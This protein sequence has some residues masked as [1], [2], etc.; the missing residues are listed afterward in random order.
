MSGFQILIWLCRTLSMVGMLVPAAAAT[1]RYVAT[2]GDDEDAGT[3]AQP[4]KHISH[5]V[6]HANAGDRIFVL[7]GTYDGAHGETFPINVYKTNQQVLSYDPDQADWARIGG[8]VADDDVVA[9]LTID[10]RASGSIAAGNR[11]GIVIKNLYF[12][13]EDVADKD[14]PHAF[15]AV[16]DGTNVVASTCSFT[17]NA[18]ERSEMNAS[19]SNGRAN[20]MLDATNGDINMLVSLNEVIAT[21]RGGIEAHAAANSATF[22]PLRRNTISVRDGETALFAIRFE[23]EQDGGTGP[24]DFTANII[25]SLWEPEQA[26]G[27]LNGIEVLIPEGGGFGH[28]NIIACEISGCRGHGILLSADGDGTETPNITLQKFARNVIV[29]N[30]GS[31]LVL[32]FDA[33]GED[34]GDGYINI[35]SQGNIIA[36][37]GDFGVEVRSLGDIS[38]GGFS[39]VNDTIA[40]NSDGGV[41]FSDLTATGLGWL[42][43]FQNAVMYGNH[44]G[45]AQVVGLGSLLDDLEAL[46]SYSDWQGYPGA[47]C[48]VNTLSNVVISCNPYFV[49][50]ANVN[51]HLELPSTCVDNGLE[52]LHVTATLDI[53]DEDRIQDGDYSCSG[54][55]DPVIDMGADEVAP[56]C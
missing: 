27:I 41:G 38:G 24:N 47:D 18:C 32:E 22:S 52:D 46:V 43:R 48:N 56:D 44:S 10:T 50:P 13:G 19:G 28:S 5:A 8:D 34:D 55:R 49:D 53:D 33:D 37:N 15:L 6:E 21:E 40:D 14:G 17:A 3:F 30:G 39:S 29:R 25:E 11:S 20:I 7:P 35:T 23:S 54:P 31:G 16:A 45:G 42:Q 36:R 51:Y 26:D 12:L 1:D 4:W 9:L 2:T